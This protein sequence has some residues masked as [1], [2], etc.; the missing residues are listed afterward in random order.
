MDGP[1]Q[2]TTQTAEQVTSDRAG[3]DQ[4]EHSDQHH[5]AQHNQTIIRPMFATVRTGH[6]FAVAVYSGHHAGVTDRR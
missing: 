4:T 5:P 1:Q 6:A 2:E 3:Q